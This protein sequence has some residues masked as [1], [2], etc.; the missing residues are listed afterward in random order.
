MAI[1]GASDRP[2][3][4]HK[5]KHEM[6]PYVRSFFVNSI[7]AGLL[8]TALTLSATIINSITIAG[9]QVTIVGNGFNGTPLVVTFNGKSIPVTNH[10]GTTIVATLNPLPPAGSYRLSVKSG[11]QLTESY[12][13]VTAGANIV[14]QVALTGQTSN[15]PTTTL[16]TPVRD[17]LYRINAYGAMTEVSNLNAEWNLSAGWQGEVG[18]ETSPFLAIYDGSTPPNAFG[19]CTIGPSQG[20]ICSIVV[21]DLAGSPLTY[22]ISGSNNP[23]PGGVYEVFITVEQLM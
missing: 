13:A 20:P 4:L 5:W 2:I 10:S 21:R 16:F 22:S 23:S 3:K 6:I 8:S 1:A 18:A 15:V 7:F 14:A 17:G 12:V 19:W 9:N 11:V